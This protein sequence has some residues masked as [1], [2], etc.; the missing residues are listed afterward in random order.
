MVD[1]TMRPP[2]PP[3]IV[4][5]AVEWQPRIL[6]RA[7]LI[8]EGFEVVATDTWSM[9]RRYLRPASKPR[10]VIVDL[11]GLPEPQS[12]LRDLRVLMR[13]DRVLVLTATGTIRPADIEQSRFRA[14]SRP[15]VIE[16]IVRAAANAIR[17]ADNMPGSVSP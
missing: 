10:L 5:L 7:Q 3:D 1:A 17:S 8:E 11:K 2:P 6:I 13:P 12:V 14:L 15:I 16:E 4:L 9:M